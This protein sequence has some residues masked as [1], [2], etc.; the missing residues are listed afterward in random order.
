[1]VMAQTIRATA[2]I[3]AGNYIAIGDPAVILK[4]G[5]PL[6]KNSKQG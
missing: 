1:M 3:G 4:Y 6:C 5:D 2:A